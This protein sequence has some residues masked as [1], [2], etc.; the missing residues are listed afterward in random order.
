M[1]KNNFSQYIG[2]YMTFTTAF[3]YEKTI[4]TEKIETIKYWLSDYNIINIYF[5]EPVEKRKKL[6]MSIKF[7]ETVGINWLGDTAEESKSN[8][9]LYMELVGDEIQ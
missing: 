9:G 8:Y 2:K 6:T 7:L 5:H 3:D 1:C 4:Y